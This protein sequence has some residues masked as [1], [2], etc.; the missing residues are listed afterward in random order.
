MTA[1]QKTIIQTLF[2][3]GNIA[4]YPNYAFRLRDRKNSVVVKFYGN[5]FQS[6]KHVLRKQKG[7]YVINKN[8]VRKFRKNTWIKKTYNQLRNA[9]I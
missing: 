1:L 3:G 2:E 4:A 5:T 7:L 9:N 8:A 6:I